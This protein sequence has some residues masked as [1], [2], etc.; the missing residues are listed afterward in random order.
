MKTE[1]DQLRDLAKFLLD[2]ERSESIRDDYWD[3][4]ED[5][6]RK[7]YLQEAIKMAKKASE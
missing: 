5:Y 2:Y 1:L 7:E 6:Y 4:S 3:G